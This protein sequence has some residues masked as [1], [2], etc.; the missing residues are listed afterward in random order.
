MAKLIK[1]V[2]DVLRKPSEEKEIVFLFCNYLYAVLEEIVLAK[3]EGGKF[4]LKCRQVY[5]QM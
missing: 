2:G 1:V 5:W 3:Q 4:N